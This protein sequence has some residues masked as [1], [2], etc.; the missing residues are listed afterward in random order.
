MAPPAGP[1]HTVHG[2][3]RRLIVVVLVLLG[4][5]CAGCGQTSGRTGQSSAP[6]ALDTSPAT[7][8]TAL[9]G[10]SFRVG[11][12]AIN[13][14][15]LFKPGTPSNL[16]DVE[17]A[18]GRD[19]VCSG[20]GNEAAVRWPRLGISGQFETLSAFGD[21]AGHAIT[22]PAVSGCDHR[23]QIQVWTLT[24]TAAHWHTGEGLRVGDPVR[25]L[26]D[27]YPRAVQD[28]SAWWL[29]TVRSPYGGTSRMADMTATVAHGMVR[30]ITVMIGAQGE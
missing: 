8:I 27:L 26:L 19:D 3:L 9:P 10:N 5:F 21:S 28:G 23:D 12:Y 7:L 13:H 29:H 2:M 24:A 18:L 14:V 16:S 1:S 11:H 4:S 30:S 22:D 25:R 20:T 6:S 15:F 17:A